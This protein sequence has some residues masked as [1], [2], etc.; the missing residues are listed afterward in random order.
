MARNKN[1]FLQNYG[2]VMGEAFGDHWGVEGDPFG[3][4]LAGLGAEAKQAYRHKANV[5][6]RHDRNFSQKRFFNKSIYNPDSLRAQYE[7]YGGGTP[8]KKGPKDPGGGFIAPP[9]WQPG[10]IGGGGPGTPNPDDDWQNTNLPAAFKAHIGNL[11]FGASPGPTSFDDWL[12][13]TQFDQANLEYEAWKKDPANATKRF[14]EFLGQG[15]WGNPRAIRERFFSQ[16]PS[17]RFEGS[18][19]YV[20][21]GRTIQY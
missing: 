1:P 11:G 5:M 18:E 6:N 10:P 19:R 20:G 15:T 3:D 9:G 16:S 12:H 2:G 13:N 4:Y 14:T 7:A 21:S 17:R 8:G